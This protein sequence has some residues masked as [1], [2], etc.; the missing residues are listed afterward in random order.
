MG[1]GKIKSMSLFE[2]IFANAKKTCEEPNRFFSGKKE[3]K[4]SFKIREDDVFL[5]SYPKSGNTWVRF[6]IANYIS[7]TKVDFRSSN[8]LVPDIHFNLDDIFKIKTSPRFIKSHFPYKKEYKKVV[9]I[10]RD[11]RDVAVSYYYHKIKTGEITGTENFEKFLYDFFLASKLEFG[12][13]GNHLKSWIQNENSSKILYIKYEDL[14]QNSLEM[15]QHIIQFSNIPFDTEKI[16]L[17]LSHSSYQSMK[18]KEN[19]DPKYFF[20]ERKL[21]N[22]GYGFIRKGEVGDWKNHFSEQMN[23]DFLKKYGDIMK[24]LKYI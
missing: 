20:E 1:N 11:G 12:D 13:W 17:A 6:L 8:Y 9:Y 24:K 7:D 4:S 14:K 23:V 10:I 5:V 18:E 15:L 3:K 16:K 22:T 19:A 2:K 21:K